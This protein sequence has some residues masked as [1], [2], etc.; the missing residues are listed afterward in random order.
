MH[1][2]PL[3]PRA[4]WLF[5]LVALVRLAVVGPVIVIGAAVGLWWWI[6]PVVG[7]GVAAAAGLVLTLWS[8]WM[9]SLAFDRWGY[10]LDQRELLIQRG[11]LVRR[12][13][14]IPV[15]RIQHVDTYQG[16]MDQLLGL[17]RLHVYTASGMGADGVIPGLDADEATRL[18]DLL[19][20]TEGDDGV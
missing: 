14:A 18:R 2:T 20:D 11:V 19:V 13:T 8:L 16:P 17:A 1:L 7:L 4:R 15:G 6:G 3:A 5:H 12:L 10:A 9:P